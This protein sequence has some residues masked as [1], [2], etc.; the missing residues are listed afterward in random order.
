MATDAATVINLDTNQ[1]PID[2]VTVFSDRAEIV[3]SVSVE[4]TK[5]GLHEIIVKG[6]PKSVKEDSFHVNAGSGKATILE[7]SY[8]LVF[9]DKKKNEQV[10]KLKTDID[11]LNAKSRALDA[12][13][14]RITNE[15]ELLTSY[16]NAIVTPPATSKGTA[17]ADLVADATVSGFAKFLTFYTSH[18]EKLDNELAD[19]EK[20]KKELNEKIKAVNT[21]LSLVSNASLE[22]NQ[23]RQVTIAIQAEK[24]TKVALGLAYMVFG[25]SWEPSY[26]VRVTTAKNAD[27]ENKAQLTYYGSIQQNSGENWTNAKLFLSTAEPASA[28]EMPSLETRA[29]QFGFNNL[30]RRPSV[31]SDKKYKQRSRKERKEERKIVESESESENEEDDESYADTASL[32]ELQKAPSMKTMRSRSKKSALSSNFEIP[33]RAN[34]DSDNKPHK[35]TIA[36]L[37]MKPQL[38]YFAIPRVTPKAYLKASV[39]NNSE[40]GLILGPANIFLDNDFVATSDLR[41]SS[42]SHAIEFLLGVDGS[43]NISYAP[44]KTVSETHGIM[45]K[46]KEIKI[47]HKTTIINTKKVDLKITIVD[48]LPLSKDEG[49]KVKLLE[50]DDLKKAG[51]KLND[52]N[53]IEWS[54]DL[55]GQSTAN[56][57]FKYSVEYPADKF[58]DGLDI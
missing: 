55:K 45:K 1:C 57:S 27:E 29:L 31:V 44:V 4:I 34:I 33:R 40:Y 49:I 37:D 46:N 14:H 41:L 8:S 32:D 28:K 17:Q 7:V 56:I 47:E 9:D 52:K 35:V 3:R 12:A 30:S 48:Q 24:E 53:N 21:Q 2:S 25:A 50:P 15:K 38:E 22:D 18:S 20:K 26:D 6:L 5:S 39:V 54:I 58:I 51:A 16:G 13:S 43:I 19:I 10:E 36:I 23:S 11:E 42:S